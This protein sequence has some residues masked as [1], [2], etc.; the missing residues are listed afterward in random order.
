MEM[1]KHMLEN[2]GYVKIPSHGTSMF[3]LIRTGNICR[4]EPVLAEEIEIGDILLFALDSGLLVGHRFIR[5]EVRNGRTY[6]ICR[7]DSRIT[8]DP[9][10]REEQILGKMVSIQKAHL[11]LWTNGRWQTAWGACIVH[12]PFLSAAIN[13]YL[14]LARKAKGMRRR[15]W[16]S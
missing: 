13:T 3:P 15:L 1:L 14:R 8:E 7:G 10:L 11:T 16:A 6:Y 12:M 9:P 2:R 4:F 5:R